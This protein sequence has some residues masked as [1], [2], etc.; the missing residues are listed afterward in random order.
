MLGHPQGNT[1]RGQL[2][3]FDATESDRTLAGRS[4]EPAGVIKVITGKSDEP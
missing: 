1:P 2:H 3:L 4:D